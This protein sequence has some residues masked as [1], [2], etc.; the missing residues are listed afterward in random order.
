MKLQ[1]LTIHSWKTSKGSLVMNSVD[2][3]ASLVSESGSGHWFCWALVLWS[4]KS[5]CL[6]RNFAVKLLLQS[7]LR[8]FLLLLSRRS[9]KQLQ[10]FK[11]GTPACAPGSPQTYLPQMGHFQRDS[12]KSWSMVFHTSWPSLNHR[13]TKLMSAEYRG[14]RLLLASG[15]IIVGIWIDTASE[16]IQIFRRNHPNWKCQ[17]SN[18]NHCSAVWPQA[19]VDHKMDSQACCSYA[20][21][22]MLSLVLDTFECFFSTVVQLVISLVGC[23]D[24]VILLLRV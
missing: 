16:T 17:L 18:W 14:P 9:L 3:V 24:G 11:F 5:P 15:L 1:L 20:E 19:T 13:E 4:R 23:Q 8:H 22:Q 21:L 12:T 7:L 10:P 6:V 2:T